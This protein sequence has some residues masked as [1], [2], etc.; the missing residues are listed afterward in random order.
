MFNMNEENQI[1]KLATCYNRIENLTNK[2]ELKKMP[3]F[4]LNRSWSYLSISILLNE[5]HN[6]VTFD[7][8]YKVTGSPNH[9]VISFKFQMEN[10]PQ[11]RI[12]ITITDSISVQMSTKMMYDSWE[13]ERVEFFSTIGVENKQLKF[14][15]FH[16]HYRFTKIINDFSSGSKVLLNNKS[17]LY[18]SKYDFSKIFHYFIKRLIFNGLP[19]NEDT[20]M[21]YKYYENFCVI[22][23]LNIFSI[24]SLEKQDMKGY[25][26]FFIKKRGNQ[27]RLAKLV[28]NDTKYS[29]CSG[30]FVMPMA[31]SLFEQN[32]EL[33]IDGFIMDT[34]W[35]IM[36][37][38]VT[39][40]LMASFLNTSLP[41]AFCFGN[42]ENKILYRNL[43]ITVQEQLNIDFA[44]KIM[45]S[46]QGKSLLTV[47]E[48]F[49]MIHL[50]CFKHLLNSL[51]NFDFSYEVIQLVRCESEFEFI[52]CKNFF[53]QKFIEICHTNEEQYEKINLALEKVGL[54]FIDNQ[55]I[56]DNEKR[57]GEVSMVERCFYHMPSTTNTLEAT[58]GHLNK[59]TPRRN[60]F[61]QSIFRIFSSSN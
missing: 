47:C 50:A 52:N 61:F 40:I 24:E 43:L 44:G 60:T 2:R 6:F 3:V 13:I 59:R 32:Q 19:H 12:W 33:E 9:P 20:Q 38:Y 30:V 31:R 54:L 26:K 7:H 45:E 34:T 42:S 53:A 37:N 55:I 25:F 23:H 15:K 11:F 49:H 18:N 46:D 17:M 35:S 41:L 1:W 29:I 16:L 4:L 39:A 22:N 21:I 48:E 51:K 10:N 8:S 56:I 5:M 14:P 36:E 28:I 27:K 57:W 58:H